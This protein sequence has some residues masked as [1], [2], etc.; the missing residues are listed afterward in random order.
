MGL[1]VYSSANKLMGVESA[2]IVK[3]ADG[4]D[5][6]N[7][8]KIYVQVNLSKYFLKHFPE[9]HSKPCQKTKMKLF[10]KVAKSFLKAVNCLRKKLHLRCFTVL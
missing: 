3:T 9:V 10:V 6:R 2:T 1:G 4:E 5:P 7:Y 8:I